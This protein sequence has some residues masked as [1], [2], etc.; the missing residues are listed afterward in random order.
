MDTTN[1]EP[2]EM[3]P[4]LKARVQKNIMWVLLASFVM[5]WSGWCSAYVVSKGSAEWMYF[6]IPQTFLYATI[7]ILLSSVT[8]TWAWFSTKR[9]NQVQTKI[10]LVLTLILALVFTR[11]QFIGYYELFDQGVVLG[12]AQSNS[13]GSYFILFV[14]FHLL[15]LLGGIIGLLVTI[16]KAFKGKYSSKNKTG[17]ELCSIYWHFL[18]GLWLYL[19]IFLQYIS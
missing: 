12:G 17:I 1:L 2:K 16:Y 11:L 18:G 5:F 3:N 19:F 10:G 8:L 6:D 7:V 9:N 15:H 14:F 4:E 13:S